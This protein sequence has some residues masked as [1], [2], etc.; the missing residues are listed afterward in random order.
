MIRKS[1]KDLSGLAQLLNLFGGGGFK[2]ASIFSVGIS[3]YITAQIIIQIMS[4]DLV[5]KLTELRKAGEMGR[6]KIELYT[7]LL[8]LPFAV[9]TSLGTLYLLN[10]EGVS[11]SHLW[12]L[13]DSDPTLIRTAG[14][15]SSGNSG[16]VSFG[17]LRTIQKALMVLVFVA[18]TYIALFL[19]DLISKKGLGNGISLLIVSGIISSIP[20]NFYNSYK[21][22]SSLE[23]GTE[24]IKLLMNIFKFLI[25]IFF[26][27]M[28]IALMVFINGS[29]RKLPIQ[30]TG[31]GLILD[32]KKLGYLP[33]KLMP[34]GIMPVVFSGSVMIFPVGIAELTRSSS[35][36]FNQFIQDYISFSSPTGLAIYFF[37]I[38]IFSFLYCQVQFNTEEM[39]R[40]F[41]KQSQFIPG[42]M[43]GQ[44]THNYLRMILNKINWLGAPML[45]L[46]TIMPNLL[47]LWTG[48]PSQVAFGGTG[49]LLL[50][51]TSLNIYEEL[52]STH[53]ISRYKAEQ[54]VELSSLEDRLHSED[55]KP[56]PYLLW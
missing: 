38:V 5:K 34:V 52:M 28:V 21:Y 47:N 35:P 15:S 6:A 41:Q 48:M 20:E 2:K 11:F 12:P 36:G 45:G 18:G 26:Y 3:P 29:T 16:F 33:I 14:D 13:P 19:S 30:Q 1:E 22:L 50:V 44:E 40:S 9:V 37:L 4:N 49:I 27:V 42:I 31:A 53:I 54:E 17:Q 32:R 51:S 7:R 43:I 55:K 25:Y 56:S 10:N 46:V 23:G 39:C 24:N 8:T